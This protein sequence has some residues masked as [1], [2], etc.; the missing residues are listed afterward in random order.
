MEVNYLLKS[1]ML[2]LYKAGKFYSIPNYQYFF[3]GIF[4]QFSVRVKE[5]RVKLNR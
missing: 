3:K 1:V 5:L 2:A 4:M